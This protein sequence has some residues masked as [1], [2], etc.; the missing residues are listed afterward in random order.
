MANIDI[1][2]TDLGIAWELGKTYTV[3]LPE[4]FVVSAT[5]ATSNKANSNLATF[6]T[7]ANPPLLQSTY[8]S[9]G[10]T[11]SLE[12]G[13]ISFT[14]DRGALTKNTGNI[15]LYKVGS[16][17][18]LINT[19]AVGDTD[20]TLDG[21][22]VNI[23]I[24]EQ[25]AASS[26]YYILTD[27][28]IVLDS[29][30]FAFAGITTTSEFTWTTDASWTA[31]LTLGSPAGAGVTDGYYNEDQTTTVTGQPILL[32]T[33]YFSGTYTLVITP[34]SGA[35]ASFTS[36]GTGSAVWNGTTY[37][38]SGSGSQVAERLA[39]LTFVPTTDYDS[40]F[41]INYHLTNPNSVVTDRTQ[42][43]IIDVTN[44]EIFNMASNRSFYQNQANTLFTSPVPYID[45]TNV[46]PSA[47]YT[48]TFNFADGGYG[49]VITGSEYAYNSTITFTGTASELNAIFPLIQYFPADGWTTN[50]S[51]TYTQSRDGFTQIANQLVTLTNLGGAG[52]TQTF[53]YTAPGVIQIPMQPQNGRY[54]NKVDVLIVGGGGSGQGSTNLSGGGGGGGVQEILDYTLPSYEYP[55][56]S[57]LTA[58]PSEPFA[59]KA[60]VGN[61]GTGESGIGGSTAVWID[62][63]SITHLG[64]VTGG[65]D[66]KNSV[67]YSNGLYTRDLSGGASG[68]I[69][70]NNTNT[71]TGYAGGVQSGSASYNVNNINHSGGGGGAGAA[72]ATVTSP[73]GGAGGNGVLS[74]LTG[75][76]FG[77]GGGG[78]GTTPG[79]GGSGGGGVGYNGTTNAVATAGADGFGGG[80]G[81]GNSTNG[82]RGGSGRAY[83][84]LRYA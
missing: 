4:G 36:T 82:A 37:T 77:G 13:T 7:P 27:A 78:A 53:N 64:I 67:V 20:V 50:S 29:G 84:R 23:S 56:S 47:S 26:S 34:T 58:I 11:N 73:T 70:S 41:T 68:T 63:G 9:N 51:F 22:K 61:G 55:V 6:G 14:L 72:G 76:Y 8:P 30:G 21:G 1:N 17:D 40:S 79:S 80:G 49:Y 74:T 35:V 33:S 12:N 25:L 16:P 75:L 46:D 5:D 57:N 44:E 15:Y 39:S 81:G 54:A 66:G 38:I 28:N 42:N 2:T 19:W 32:E 45:E 60:Q 52:F 18:V 48:I 69:D 59:L 24:V 43:M 83:I 10:S 62:D 71:D 65:R 31:D 3:V